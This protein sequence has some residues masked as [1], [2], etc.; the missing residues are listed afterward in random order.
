LSNAIGVG[1]SQLDN[2]EV[3]S[4]IHDML[5]Y[6]D[7]MG[8]MTYDFAGPWSSFVGFNAAIGAP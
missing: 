7:R 5:P 3:T 1:N 2:W 6:L 8:L 4:S